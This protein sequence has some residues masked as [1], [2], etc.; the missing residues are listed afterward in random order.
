MTPGGRLVLL[1]D[2]NRVLEINR[3]TK[4]LGC[5]EE[6]W[7]DSQTWMLLQPYKIGPSITKFCILQEMMDAA[8]S[9]DQVTGRCQ[10]MMLFV[11][12]GMTIEELE[13]IVDLMYSSKRN[14]NTIFE[15]R[16]GERRQQIVELV[17]AGKS[18][19]EI[20]DILRLMYGND[21]LIPW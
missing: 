18:T 6:Y 2:T 10:L 3:H 15:E 9:D 12:W 7:N 8:A 13:E 14:A 17:M 5:Y 20:Q 16:D 1:A 4:A 21:S 19:D 11:R